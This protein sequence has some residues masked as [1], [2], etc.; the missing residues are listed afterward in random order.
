MRHT[1]LS[2]VPPSGAP[3]KA[4]S[5]VRAILKPNKIFS[6]KLRLWNFK[7]ELERLGFLDVDARQEQNEVIT[8]LTLAATFDDSKHIAEYIFGAIDV[9][10][11]SHDDFNCHIALI[12]QGDA[13][14]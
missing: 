5:C 6:G 1:Y 7:G 3:F 11:Y 12:K 8:E 10:G 13:P 2:E 4:Y 9:I 14:N